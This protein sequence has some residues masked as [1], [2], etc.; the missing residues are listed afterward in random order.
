MSRLAGPGRAAVLA[1]WTKLGSVRSDLAALVAVAAAMVAGT[2]LV[3]AGMDLPECAGACLAGGG[4]PGGDRA[5]AGCSAPDGTLTLVGVHF[6]QLAVIVLAVAGMAAE[7]QPRLLRVTFAM[8][9][10]RA[11]VFWA[12][13]AV[14]AGAVVVSAGVGPVG[15]ARRADAA[16]APHRAR[17][18]R[19]VGVGGGRHG[20]IPGP[21]RA[22]QPR[23]RRRDPERTCRVGSGGRR[24]T[25][26]TC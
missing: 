6:A 9:P 26:H 13:A 17:R 2:L 20:G 7:F 5:S 22:A 11:G 1:E 3:V 23:R 25:G 15:D 4:C 8:R 18:G 12:K 24:S 14:V 10:E 21:H 19:A 16:G